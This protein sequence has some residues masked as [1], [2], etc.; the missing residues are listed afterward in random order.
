VAVVA[1][2]ERELKLDPPDGFALPQLPGEPLTSRVFVSTYYDTADR[3]LARAGITLRRRDEYG[4][5]AWQLKLPRDSSRL[6]IEHQGGAAHPPEELENALFAVTR[7]EQLESIA[8]LRTR[9][10]GMLV[11]DEERPVAE[12]VLDDVAVM[13]GNRVVSAFR[14]LEIEARDGDRRALGRIER[15]LRR[16]GATPGNGT[17]KVLRALGQDFSRPAPKPS[18]PAVEHLRA[19]IA[20]QLAAILAHDP[21]IRLGGTTEDVHQLRVATRRLRSVL[22]TA[23]PLVDAARADSLRD[24]LKWLGE[25]LGTVRDLDVLIEYLEHESESLPAAEQR[26]LAGVIG[27]LAASRADRRASLVEQLSTSRYLAVLDALESLQPAESKATLA[28][29]AAAEFK[30]ARKAA[31]HTETD[32]ELHKLRV[33]LK[34]A[35]Y[36]AEL[37]ERA[38]GKPAVKFVASAKAFQDVA[39]EHQDAVVAEERLRELA[40]QTGRGKA[41]FVLGRLVERQEPRRDRARAGVPAAWK[42]VKKRGLKAWR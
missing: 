5:S 21:A 37:A 20:A 10:D 39:G 30:R 15:A 41:L 14:E 23:R 35:R 33:R 3:R 27:G 31:R 4:L 26:A 8:R 16:A 19:M 29:L 24:E 32:E 6:E 13:D 40:E 28:E 17:P 12:V 25:A 9:R 2:D 36:A 22:R 7:G 38:V 42:R 18:A 34:R 1:T 11:S